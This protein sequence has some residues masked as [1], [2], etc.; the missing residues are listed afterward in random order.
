MPQHT[1]PPAGMDARIDQLISLETQQVE[2]SC[3]VTV[4]GEVDMVTTPHLRS[5]LQQQ[6]EQA[7]SRLVVDLRGVAFLGSSGLAVLVEILDWTRER[8]IALRLVCD[9]REVLRPL[10]AT[11]LTEL[12]E[13]HADPAA[14]LAAS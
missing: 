9:S 11:G 10:E 8:D 13:I 14:A 4:A 2:G 1:D 5:Y 12:F 7:D 6:V 3:L